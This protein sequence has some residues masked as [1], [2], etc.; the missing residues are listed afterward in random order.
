[1]LVTSKKLDGRADQHARQAKLIEH[2][3]NA[4][5]FVS[6]GDVLAILGQPILY[7][8]Q[9]SD[10]DMER[11]DSCGCR[12][13]DRRMISSATMRASGFTGSTGIPSSI[14][15]RRAAIPIP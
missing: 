9:G 11:I 6:I 12:L 10:G 1:M 4:E 2:S 13:M 3:V 15:N 7:A 5:E 8:S 14:S